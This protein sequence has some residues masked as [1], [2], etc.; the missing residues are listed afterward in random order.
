MCV[1]MVRWRAFNG[2]LSV[3]LWYLL[4]LKIF[5]LKLDNILTLSFCFCLKLATICLNFYL[6]KR[7]SIRT[8]SVLINFLLLFHLDRVSDVCVCEFESISV[9]VYCAVCCIYLI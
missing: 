5:N 7:E 3:C 1:S 6:N 4:F 2:F 9:K 8:F